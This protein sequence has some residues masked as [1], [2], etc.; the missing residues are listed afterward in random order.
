MEGVREGLKE[1]GRN[2]VMRREGKGQ[3]NST[4]GRKGETGEERV[5]EGGIGMEGES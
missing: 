3:G 5:R 1:D 4:I 2:E